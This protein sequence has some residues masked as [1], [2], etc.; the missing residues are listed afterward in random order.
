VLGALLNNWTIRVSGDGN[1]DPLLLTAAQFNREVARE[2]IR[3]MRR[4]IPFCLITIELHKQPSPRRRLRV[5][6][7]LLQ[8]HL[9]MTDHKGLIGRGRYGVLLVDTPGPGG[10]A[11]VERLEALALRHGLSVT[12]HLR[13]HDP[14]GSDSNPHDPDSF[15]RCDDVA[16]G[17]S[18][19][20]V[21]VAADDHLI[22]RPVARMVI[23]RGIDIVG[24]SIG[25]VVTSPIIVAAMLAIKWDDSGPALYKQ[26]REGYRGRTF[27]II[28]LRTM[29][30]DAEHSQ[31]DLRAHSHRDGPAFKIV[32]DPRVTRVGHFLR[33]TCIDELPQ[34]WN[35]IKGD[36]SL[37]GPR[38]LPLHESRA[39]D[40]WHRR[41]LDVRPG[42]T[43]DWQIDKT[44]ADTFDEWMRLD[45][46]Y[47]D[48][49]SLLRDLQLIVKTIR[50]PLAGRGSE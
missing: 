8:H 30:V 21:E 24:G 44:Q 36:M 37:V 27:T 22:S 10:R 4:S 25:L 33:K 26:I 47:I 35:V 46:R 28:K 45:L 41:R 29:V 49:F 9:R 14:E 31:S 23:K 6:T 18:R 42:L 48:R 7:R 12:M 3:A 1:A 5:L 39:C 19:G 16:A 20:Q 17:W 38:P 34:L 11:T 13:M 32:R 2:R 15:R 43:C 50:V 40:R